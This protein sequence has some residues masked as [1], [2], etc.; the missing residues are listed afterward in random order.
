MQ[1]SKLLGFIAAMVIAQSA[2]SNLKDT[3]SDMQTSEPVQLIDKGL[4]MILSYKE[5]GVAMKQTA[6]FEP[7]VHQSAPLADTICMSYY[8]RQSFPTVQIAQYAYQEAVDSLP[9]KD[10]KHM[11]LAMNGTDVSYYI[12]QYE[13][14]TKS[15]V[16]TY[17]N[18]LYNTRKLMEENPS[19]DQESPNTG[20][21]FPD[22]S[23]ITPIDDE[24]N[25]NGTDENNND[26]NGDDDTKSYDPQYYE[27]ED[28]LHIIFS[29][30]QYTIGVHHSYDVQFG[31]RQRYGRTDTVCTQYHVTDTYNS[32]QYAEWQYE[33]IDFL[34]QSKYHYILD[35]AVI[36]YNDPF[37]VGVSKAV[38]KYYFLDLQDRLIRFQ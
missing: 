26:D 2:C 9:E 27:S 19:L 13:G 16:R 8:V 20:F 32:V 12:P 37:E 30:N 22:I 34:E 4:E 15:V 28:G 1:K 29:W 17:M 35:G 6:S 11:R 5:A 10:I 31:I 23:I 21:H 36:T 25:S 24:N 14:S 3:I 7:A 33:L 18:L 38:I